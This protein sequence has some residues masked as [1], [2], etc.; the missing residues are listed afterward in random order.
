[1]SYKYPICDVFHWFCKEARFF[2]T[3][4]GTPFSAF[5]RGCGIFISMHGNGR[6]LCIGNIIRKHQ[7]YKGRRPKIDLSL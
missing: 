3:Q 7:L 1:M 5:K 6:I 4:P 2:A